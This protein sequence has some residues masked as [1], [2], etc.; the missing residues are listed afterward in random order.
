M[1]GERKNERRNAKERK[2]EWGNTKKEK[3]EESKRYRNVVGQGL[4]EQCKPDRVIRKG[5]RKVNGRKK[6]I[7]RKTS[8]PFP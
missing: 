4:E 5:D 6:K 7:S 2:N 3:K 8:S 1:C